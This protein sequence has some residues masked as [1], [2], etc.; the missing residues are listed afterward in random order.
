MPFW[1]EQVARLSGNSRLQQRLRRQGKEEFVVYTGYLENN[2][3]SLAYYG[4]DS[5]LRLVLKRRRMYR[6]NRWLVG[7]TCTLIKLTGR[8]AKTT[9]ARTPWPTSANDGKR[10]A[11]AAN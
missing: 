5:L 1:D 6:A 10:G 11:F 8:M 7:C 9:R 3:I 4:Q 2:S